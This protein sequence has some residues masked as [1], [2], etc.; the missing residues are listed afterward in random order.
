MPFSLCLCVG[1]TLSWE[2]N[3]WFWDD[4]VVSPGNALLALAV[5]MVNNIN[6][7]MSRPS[8]TAALCFHLC[9]HGDVSIY[10]SSIAVLWLQPLINH[11]FLLFSG[12]VDF[13]YVSEEC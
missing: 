3:Q 1:D 7:V 13:V 9:A 11:V 2:E 12:V 6:C 4:E 8:N 10:N 5:A